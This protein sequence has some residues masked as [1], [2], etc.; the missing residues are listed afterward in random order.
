M[1]ELKCDMR[2]DIGN[3]I[4]GEARQTARH[5]EHIVACL[6][7]FGILKQIVSLCERMTASTCVNDISVLVLGGEIKVTSS[8]NWGSMVKVIDV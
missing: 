7:V 5:R 1:V 2:A 8:K 6:R 3:I 4:L